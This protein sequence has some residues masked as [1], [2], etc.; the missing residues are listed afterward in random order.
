MR[1]QPIS[2]VAG[3]KTREGETLQQPMQSLF[4]L[5]QVRVVAQTRAES[6]RQPGLARV[7]FPRMHIKDERNVLLV[8][9][10]QSPVGIP[11]GKDAQVTPSADRKV[12]RLYGKRGHRVLDEVAMG[13]AHQ[14]GSSRS[15]GNA[16]HVVG[17][18]KNARVVGKTELGQDL[19]SPERFSRN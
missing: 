1:F 17:N 7:D 13:G 15:I 12:A 19:Q 5:I 4:H 14:R 11:E 3:A 18:G 8:C 16:V 10:P 2:Q 9:G 6:S